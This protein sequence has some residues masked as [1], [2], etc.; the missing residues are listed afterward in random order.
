EFDTVFLA[1]WEEGTFPH[2]KSIDEGNLEEERRLAYVGITRAKSKA[3]IL[4][5]MNRLIHGTWQNCI[6]SR[7]I[8]EIPAEHV[9]REDST[10]VFKFNPHG[11][12]E[13][14]LGFS[15]KK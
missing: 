13:P 12:R 6:P 10:R 1:G 7:F 9:S 11:T 14:Y 5:A 4:C 2:Q 15:S 8:D 3:F